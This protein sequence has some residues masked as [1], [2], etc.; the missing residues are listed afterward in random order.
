MKIIITAFAL[1]IF[2]SYL[3]IIRTKV[4]REKEKERKAKEERRRRKEAEEKHIN[5]EKSI[6]CGD[7]I[8]RIY[9]N[10]MYGILKESVIFIGGNPY[11]PYTYTHDTPRDKARK[12]S[13]LKKANQKIIYDQGVYV[14]TDKILSE[15]TLHFNISTIEIDCTRERIDSISFQKSK[16][17]LL[18]IGFEICSKRQNF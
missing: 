3:L 1:L 8:T 14:I 18:P 6:L 7:G 15:L 16:W 17:F 9:K 10:S 12:E 13:A 11:P 2:A 4:K 5:I